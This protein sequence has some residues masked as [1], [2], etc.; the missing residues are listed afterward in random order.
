MPAMC[1]ITIKLCYLL[2][3]A[4][5]GCMYSLWLRLA[6]RVGQNAKASGFPKRKEGADPAWRYM[7]A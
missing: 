1:M 3:D 7:G 4:I 6:C 5:A 2:R